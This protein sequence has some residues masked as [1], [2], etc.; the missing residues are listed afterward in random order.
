MHLYFY[1]AITPTGLTSASFYV[2]TEPPGLVSS[3]PGFGQHGKE[4]AD[5]GESTGVSSWIGA[6]CSTDR[7]LINVDHFINVMNSLDGFDAAD[8]SLKAIKFLAQGSIDNT[9]D[10]AALAGT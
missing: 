3:H 8:P 9:I 5:M 4:F 1:Y 7:T 10:Q 6:W 2:K